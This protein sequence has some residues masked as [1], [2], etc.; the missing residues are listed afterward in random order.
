MSGKARERLSPSK[1]RDKPVFQRL[2]HPHRFWIV[3]PVVAGS[4]PVAH[5][6]RIKDLQRVILLLPPPTC[7]L[8]SPDGVWP[9]HSRPACHFRASIGAYDYR[10]WPPRVPRCA[11]GPAATPH[12]GHTRWLQTY[13]PSAS[14]AFG[15]RPWATVAEHVA[16]DATRRPLVRAS[17]GYERPLGGSG[18]AAGRPLAYGA[19]RGPQRSMHRP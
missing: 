8:S 19:K 1:S 12:A 3:A 5:P 18:H 14:V 13:Q 16:S 7:G 15:G 6:P 10:R 9:P 17:A 11:P 4:S 2:S